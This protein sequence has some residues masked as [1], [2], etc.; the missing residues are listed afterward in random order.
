[1][2]QFWEA[3]LRFSCQQCGRC[4]CGEPGIVYFSPEEFER[5]VAFLS[6]TRQLGRDQII[7]EY[8]KPWRDSYTARDDFEDG[9]CVFYDHGCTVYDVRPSQCRDFPFWRCQLK[10]EKAWQD[11]AKSCPG[12]NKGRLWSADEICAIAAN[13][14]I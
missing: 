1:M 6:K 14:R 2:K 3:G 10:N 9:H 7:A 4:C 11:A 5:L 13:S 12:M 8:M